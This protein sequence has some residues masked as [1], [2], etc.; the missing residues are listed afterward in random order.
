[1]NND[2]SPSHVVRV[3]V[4]I[5]PT[6]SGKETHDNRIADVVSAIVDTASAAASNTTRFLANQFLS[7]SLSLSLC[8]VLFL[9]IKYSCE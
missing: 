7:L 8:F 5:I 2:L 1:M 9:S 3:E 4:I 6:E